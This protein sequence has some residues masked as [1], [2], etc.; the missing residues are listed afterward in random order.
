[1]SVQERIKRYKSTG[2]AARLV[3]VEVLVPS[4]D[5]AQILATAA[6]LRARHRAPKPAPTAPPVNRETVNDRAKLILHRLVAGHLRRGNQLLVEARQRFKAMPQPVPEYVRDWLEIL[7]HSVDEVARLIV[8]RSEALAR[9]RTASPSQLP[10][11]YDDPAWRRRVWQ[12][13]K[14]GGVR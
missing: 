1:M 9:L 12:K 6:E 10:A 2:G 8:K 14:L 4:E 7:D 3:Q 5:R 13:A 11:A